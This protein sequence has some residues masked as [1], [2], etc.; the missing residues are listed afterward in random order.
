[1][2]GTNNN[3][4]RFLPNHISVQW[5]LIKFPFHESSKCHYNYYEMMKSMQA[6]LIIL[7]D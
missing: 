5:N 7:I 1:M 4:V 6:K 2:N 3:V